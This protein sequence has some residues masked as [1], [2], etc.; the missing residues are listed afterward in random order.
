MV[1]RCNVVIQLS[2]A[3]ETLVVLDR[4]P[5]LVMQLRLGQIESVDATHAHLL[6]QLFWG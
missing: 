4:A 6:L 3:E 2:V 1:V 5:A